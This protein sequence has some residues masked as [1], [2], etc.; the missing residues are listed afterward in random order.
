M[1]SGSASGPDTQQATFLDGNRVQRTR[2]P[3]PIPKAL[4]WVTKERRSGQARGRL[5]HIHRLLTYLA[6]SLWRG[7]CY[8]RFGEVAAVVCVTGQ[9]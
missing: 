3:S 6:L 9:S 2:T 1:E 7:A 8:G 4:Y 5:Q